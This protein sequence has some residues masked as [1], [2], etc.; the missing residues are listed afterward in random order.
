MAELNAMSCTVSLLVE[1][2][3]ETSGLEDW[4]L[5]IHGIE[6]KFK[7]K[8]REYTATYL[9]G[10]VLEQRWSKLEAIRHLILKSGYKG[11][12]TKEL[13]ESI[14]VTRYKSLKYDC[15]YQEYVAFKNAKA[16]I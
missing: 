6:I 3:H 16:A 12:I 4:D 11:S 8:S 9:P 1:F 2:E 13:K 15:T 5:E 7:H 14:Q 10:V